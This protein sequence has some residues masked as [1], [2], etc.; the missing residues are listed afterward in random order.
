MLGRKD[1]TQEELDNARAAV[2]AQLAAFRQL[3]STSGAGDLEPV[4]FT[5]MALVLDR[6]FVHRL[7]MTA[8]K[9]GNPVNEL[10]LIAD[11]LLNNGGV[12]RGNNVVKYDPETSVLGL[13]PGDRIEITADDFERLADAFLVEL[14]ARFV[15]GSQAAASRA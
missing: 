15:S 1:Y 3:G 4:L 8:G 5:N 7:R 9:D 14:D 13:R 11:S 6:Y 2:A 10:E 12:L